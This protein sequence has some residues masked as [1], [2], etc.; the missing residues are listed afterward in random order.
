MSAALLS[1]QAIRDALKQVPDWTRRGSGLRRTFEF[2]D[3][4][5]AL[6]FVNAVGRAAE[7]AGHHPDIDI[8][9]NRV[10]LVLTS[11]DAGGLTG[12]DFDLAAKISNLARRQNPDSS[13]TA[14]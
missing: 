14:R 10:T 12:L 2:P 8:R 7:K 4:P 13:R 1:P 11:H 5:A 6:K 9:W 3:F